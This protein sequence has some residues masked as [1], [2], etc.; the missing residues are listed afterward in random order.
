MVEGMITALLTGIM[1]ALIH[2]GVLL[3]KGKLARRIGARKS[4]DQSDNQDEAVEK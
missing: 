3:L 2:S 4:G 1:M